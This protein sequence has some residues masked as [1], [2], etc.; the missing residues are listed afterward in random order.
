MRFS[1][2]ASPEAVAVMKEEPSLLDRL[3]EALQDGRGLPMVIKPDD[4]ERY[5]T[6][7]EVVTAKP[8]G[9]DQIKI[10]KTTKIDPL[11]P[12]TGP[13]PKDKTILPDERSGIEVKPQR[14]VE[15]ISR[16]ITTMM[17]KRT[18]G[19]DLPGAGKD[20]MPLAKQFDSDVR[21]IKDPSDHMGTQGKI[22]DFKKLFQSRYKKIRQILTQQYG[23]LSQ[24]ENIGTLGGAED[25]VRFVGI[26]SSSRTTKNGHMMID[27]EDQTGNIRALISKKKQDL[28]SIKVVEDEVIGIV[29]KYKSGDGRGGAI[30]FIDKIF[31]ADIPGVHRRRISEDK[32]LLAVFTSDIHIGS[33]M[34]LE[35]EWDR[36][37][38]W[39]RGEADASLRAKDGHRVKYFVVAGDLVDGI[40]IYPDQDK[41]L[42]YKDIT[43]QYEALAESLAMVPDHIEIILMPGNHDAVRLAEPQPPLSKEFQDL[44]SNSNLHFLSNPTSFSVSGVHVAGYHGKS[45]DDMVT[46]F[47]E[48][49]YEEPIEGMKEMLRSRHYGPSYGMR[50]QL[51][52]EDQDL[53]VIEDIPD[54][55]VS[56]HVHRYGMDN[57]K[58]IQLI[59]GSTWQ[60]QT[61]FQKMMNLKPQPAK[62]GVVEL[63]KPNDMRTWE[64]T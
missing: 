27:L 13:S 44:F 38:R 52:P 20:G 59:E 21:I 54:I 9:D 33:K 18:T 2:L 48:V 36:M 39:L 28:M 7:G 26:V 57:Y 19:I 47:K 24:C 42:I 32:G 22:D 23:D 3:E 14:Q 56:G 41:D 17:K 31:K 8:F 25:H 58:G 30:V 43:K 51:A 5:L 29:G 10:E 16:S 49:T 64:I 53:L 34:Y 15:N 1:R 12:T 46:L 50:N 63:S 45:I 37:V 35:K 61:P 4:L 6:R 40:G 55:F 11:I 60:S 62:M